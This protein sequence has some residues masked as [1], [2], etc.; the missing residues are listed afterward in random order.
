MKIEKPNSA[1]KVEMSFKEAGNLLKRLFKKKGVTKISLKFEL[2]REHEKKPLV[3]TTVHTRADAG[4][5]NVQVL[6]SPRSNP[7]ESS[8]ELQNKLDAIKASVENYISKNSLN[9]TWLDWV[10]TLKDEMRSGRSTEDLELRGLLFKQAIT[11]IGYSA[12]FAA[13]ILAIAHVIEGTEALARND[14]EQ[15]SRNVKWGTYWSGEGMFIPDP[16]RRFE[17]RARTGGRGKA[18][19]NE[20]VKKKV[21]ELLLQSPSPEGW[22]STSQAVDEVADELTG[23]YSQFVENHG[24]KCE[25]LA[26]TI[27]GWL[28]ESPDRFPHSVKLQE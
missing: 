25:N 16:T 22:N 7:L 9:D 20:E 2:Y 28:E 27:G 24:L 17:A 3:I 21:A 26:R 4:K 18:A 10:V 11:G 1:L 13:P 6:P 15:A 14:L 19:R 5:W 8:D 12:H 23:E